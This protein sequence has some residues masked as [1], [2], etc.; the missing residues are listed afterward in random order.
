MQNFKAIGAPPPDPRFFRRLGASCPDPQN[1]PPIVN[2]W[3]RAWQLFTVYNYMLF[4]SF[5][6]E[7]FFLDRSV[8]TL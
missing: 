7:Q 6:F 8:A 4:C 3:L 2:F 1:S 5:R